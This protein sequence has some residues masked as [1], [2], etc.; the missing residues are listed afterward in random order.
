MDNRY[1]FVDSWTWITLGYYVLLYY[2][3]LG[4]S[5]SLW[6]QYFISTN[7][8]ANLKKGQMW[9][10]KVISQIKTVVWH[11]DADYNVIFKIPICEHEYLND[12]NANKCSR[13]LSFKD[14]RHESLT[15]SDF[16]GEAKGQMLQCFF[17]CWQ[18]TS[19]L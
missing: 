6:W 18:Y 13:I 8:E 4:S 19:H 3:T 15:L 1:S 10:V 9:N 17:K 12:A 7:F 2:N 5:F 14:K 16:E 11:S